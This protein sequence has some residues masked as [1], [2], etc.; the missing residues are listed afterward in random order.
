MQ[1]SAPVTTRREIHFAL[2]FSDHTVST[3][4]AHVGFPLTGDEIA[5]VLDHIDRELNHLARSVTLDAVHARIGELVRVVQSAS[6]AS[7][8]A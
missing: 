7:D 4:A 1:A 2:D 8:G 3:I 6:H 5:V